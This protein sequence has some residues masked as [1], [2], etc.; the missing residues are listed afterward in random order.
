MNAIK[1]VLVLASIVVIS[2]TLTSCENTATNNYIPAP[3]D[4]FTLYA[5]DYSDSYYFVD[6]LYRRSFLEY[7]RDTITSYKLNINYSSLIADNYVIND[8]L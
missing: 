8:K 4:N 6:T 2:I 1:I 7:Y 5:W 3:T